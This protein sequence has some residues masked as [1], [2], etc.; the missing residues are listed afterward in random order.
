VAALSEREAKGDLSAVVGRV[1][2]AGQAKE[3]DYSMAGARSAN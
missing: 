2:N 3:F 1:S